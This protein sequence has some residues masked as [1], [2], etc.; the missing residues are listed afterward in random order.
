MASPLADSRVAA[1]PKTFTAVLRRVFEV[2]PRT[3]KR[4]LAALL[5]GMIFMAMVETA[6]AGLIALFVG[7]VSGPDVLLESKNFLTLRPLLGPLAPTTGR[8]LVLTL[9]LV[10][11]AAVSGKNLLAGMLNY[12]AAKI[13]GLISGFFGTCFLRGAVKMPYLWHTKQNSA[14]IVTTFFFRDQ[15]GNDLLRTTL[16]MCCDALTVVMLGFSLMFIDPYILLATGVLT[17]VFSLLIYKIIRLHIDRSSQQRRTMIYRFNQLVSQLIHGIKDIKLLPLPP[18]IASFSSE[19]DTY[20][21]VMASQYFFIN[22]VTLFFECTGVMMVTGIV[23]AILFSADVSV[24]RV[25]GT[26][27]FFVVAAWRIL[28]AVNRILGGLSLLRGSL[29]TMATFLGYLGLFEKNQSALPAG[30]GPSPAFRSEIALHDLDF[31]YGDPCRLA[32]SGINLRIGKGASI[33]IVGPSGSGKTTLVDILIGFLEPTRGTVC[34]DGREANARFDT[35]WTQRIGYVPQ[36]PYIVDG[37]LLVNIAFGETHETADRERVRACCDQANITEFLDRLPQGLDTPIGERGLQLSGGQRQ[38]VAIARAL[39][40]RPEII[41]LDEATSALDT[42][43]EKYIQRT[44][45]M[46]RHQVTS[47]IIAHRLSTVEDCDIIVWLENGRIKRM[48]EA[49][50]V[51]DAYQRHLK[52]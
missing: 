46:L 37:S 32:L 13:S 40:K 17:A 45:A 36:T 49:S 24:A 9:C 5:A 42:K 39:Y 31:H 35:A 8:E 33:G 41:I 4:Q 29:P 1:E 7:A 48:G 28:P 27:S 11:V 50:S 25:S 21:G 19:I 2:L 18:I 47:V 52:S 12:F 34:I 26:V 44:M 51:L 23:T 3:R 15:I 16:Q 38:R 30:G 14:D 6:V 43:S 10:V 20:A 22:A